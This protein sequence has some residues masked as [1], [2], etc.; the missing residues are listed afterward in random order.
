[1]VVLANGTVAGGGKIDEVVVFWPVDNGAGVG[2][3]S[4]LT[5][6]AMG[7]LVVLAF[8]GLL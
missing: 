6:P 8:V 3:A 1:V 7:A 2:V 4:A 5:L